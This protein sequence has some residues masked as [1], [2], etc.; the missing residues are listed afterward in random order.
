MGRRASAPHN[1]NG[2]MLYKN[3]VPKKEPPTRKWDAEGN[4]IFEKP[5]KEPLPP[6]QSAKFAH[7][8]FKG[9]KLSA[10]PTENRF[11]KE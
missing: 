7:T 9:G 11:M 5:E 10:H 6:P 3:L 1:G 2:R 8:I 4:E